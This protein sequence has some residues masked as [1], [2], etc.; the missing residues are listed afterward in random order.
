MPSP[1]EERQLHSRKHA[2]DNHPRFPQ[3]ALARR[4]EMMESL[5]EG[6]MPA[7]RVIR[8][9]RA[10][11]IHSSAALK[12]KTQN[13]DMKEQSITP[14]PPAEIMERTQQKVDS[15][16]PTDSVANKNSHRP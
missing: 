16:R 9:S 13:I 8:A 3:R 14:T 7:A 2:A 6:E 1:D 15:D 5:G 4:E 12:N 11:K 10:P